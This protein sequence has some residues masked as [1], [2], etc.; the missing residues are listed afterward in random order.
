M[1]CHVGKLSQLIVGTLQ[2]P[3]HPSQMLFR[4]LA[5]ANV[6]DGCRHQD[7]LSAFEGAQH[8]LDREIVSI[9]PP[10]VELNPRADLL[11]QGLR[12]GSRTV[13]DQPL[14]K[15]L[16]NDVLDLLPEEFIPA[17]SELFLR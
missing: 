15:T 6:P 3:D 10:P 14:R 9:L 5:H 4:V 11:R 16:W 7:P 2:L 13:S 17:V 12:R 1:G 8:D